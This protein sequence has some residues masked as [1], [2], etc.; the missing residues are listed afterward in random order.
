MFTGDEVS[1]ALAVREWGA[2]FCRKFHRGD[3][4]ER[5]IVQVLRDDYPGVQDSWRHFTRDLVLRPL[6]SGVRQAVRGE[7]PLTTGQYYGRLNAEISVAGVGTDILAVSTISSRVWS[8]DRDQQRY[9]DQNISAAARGAKIRRLFVLP[10]TLPPDLARLIDLQSES[11]IEVRII[12]PEH[13]EYFASLED[14]VI[15]CGPKN[16]SQHRGY[17]ALPAINNPGKV[18]GGRLVLNRQQ[19]ELQQQVFE[20]A[21]DFGANIED[22]HG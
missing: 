17:V 15:F 4:E 12:A 5:E 2:R 13:A 1:D 19:C 8:T 3:V 22:G 20:D 10:D 6:L 21:W 14:I 16:L 9:Y 18:R 11:G 7:I